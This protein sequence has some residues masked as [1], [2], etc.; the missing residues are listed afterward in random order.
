[1]T[2]QTIWKKTL[3]C[4]LVSL[5]VHAAQAQSW[6]DR[7]KGALTKPP[8]T[9]EQAQEAKLI[10]E[11]QNLNPEQIKT[12]ASAFA[13]KVLGTLTVPVLAIDGFAAQLRSNV[14]QVLE[15]LYIE[16]ERNATLNLN[17]LGL[18]ALHLGE[19]DFAGKTLDMATARIEMVYADNEEA[20]KA[21]SVWNAERIKDFK[22][23]PY[24]RVMTHFYRGLAYAA[25]GDFQNA[26]A[27]FKQAEYQD[28]VAESEV[29]GSDFALMPY[30]AGWASHCDGNANLANDF[31][32]AAIKG[33]SSYSALKVDRP[34]VVLFEAGRA[35]QKI[36]AGQHKEQLTFQ[37]YGLPTTP[38]REVCEASTGK[39]K[40]CLT[41]SMIVGADLGFQATT[42]GGRPF[43]AIM[44]GKASFKDGAQTVAQVGETVGAVGLNLAGQTGNRDAAGLGFL[45]MFVGMAAKTVAQ[46]TNTEADTREWEQ[47]P[48]QVW[49]GAGTVVSQASSLS[50]ALE[51]GVNFS[52]RKLVSTPQCQL[53]WGRDNHQ[54]TLLSL[55]ATLEPGRHKRDPIFR[56][57][58]EDR[59]G[60]ATK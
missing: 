55:A 4:A 34:M 21:K 47:L 48:G 31:L 25:K 41:Q 36:G 10:A 12:N 14:K 28:T 24:E 3:I 11:A 51:G 2:Q 35:P 50:V 33:D 29:Y 57:D 20:Q 32:Q 27:L 60:V 39:T 1:M 17:R 6:M 7:L 30:M 58:I 18:M 22:G 16:G 45:G 19:V 56:R 43:D 23:E 15:R 54:S 52:A 37:S 44:N 13:D 26:R 5:S 8:E 53:Y 59:L 9:A 38:V 46:A 42:R 40:Q 49:L